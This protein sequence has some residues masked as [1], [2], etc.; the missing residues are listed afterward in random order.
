MSGLVDSQIDK[1]FLGPVPK[2]SAEDFGV[3]GLNANL[4]EVLERARRVANDPA[5]IA[6]RHVRPFKVK[7]SYTPSP[8]RNL[9]EH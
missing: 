1:W 7:P 3:I 6:W 4:D 9:P 5:E 8:H 2:F